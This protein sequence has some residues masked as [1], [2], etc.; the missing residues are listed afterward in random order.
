MK[1]IIRVVLIA[2][3]IFITST[4]FSFSNQNAEQ[5]SGV[6]G[7]VA[8]VL[9]NLQSKY[10]NITK[11]EKEQL[12]EKY[13]HP[14]RKFAHFSI[15]TLLG[16]SIAGLT[17]TYEITNKKRILITII[18]GALYAMTD[19][20]HQTFINGRSG[21]ITDVMLDT[22]GVIVGCI[23]VFVFYKLLINSKHKKIVEKY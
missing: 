10:K 17:C 7:K 22:T 20:F 23:I 6:S 1:M 12:I 13:Q 16:I 4:I 8:E 3:I 9:I 19:E 11:E 5:S 21:E 2:I 14:V 18:S 15:Y